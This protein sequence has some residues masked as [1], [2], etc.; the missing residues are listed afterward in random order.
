MTDKD[1][2]FR[3]PLAYENPRFL[4]GPDGRPLRIMAEYMEPLARFR[5]EK[6]QDTVVF[7][8]SA[9]FADLEHAESGLKLLEMP[10]SATPAPPDEQYKVKRARAAVDMARYYEDAHKHTHMLTDW[11]N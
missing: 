8:G 7:F 3:S 10:G 5:R 9:R 2:V 1:K 4:N 11:T 6:V